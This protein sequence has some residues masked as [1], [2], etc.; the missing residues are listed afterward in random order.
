MYRSE[1]PSQV[2]LIVL[3][4]LFEIL[5]NRPEQEWK[6]VI[7]VYDNMCHLDS[8]K[9]ATIPLSLPE[10]YCNMWLKVRKIID[11]LHIRNHTDA[12]CLEK[13]NPKGVKECF[14]EMNLMAAEQTFV[15]A[16]RFKKILC[17]MPKTHH[18]FYLHRYVP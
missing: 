14:P 6:D 10:H 1:S 5:K 12:R 9:V 18:C 3:S 13:Y 15:W 8:L 16:S 4:F 11:S 7:L 2:F 17:S